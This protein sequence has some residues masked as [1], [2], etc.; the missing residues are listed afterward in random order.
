MNFHFSKMFT[1]RETV[2]RKQIYLP[3]SQCFL[4]ENLNS[5]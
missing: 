2:L 1:S 4:R 3:S 5:S